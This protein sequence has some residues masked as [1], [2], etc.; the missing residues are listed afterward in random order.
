MSPTLL[1]DAGIVS[2]SANR[3]V[4]SSL[5]AKMATDDGRSL[6]ERARETFRQL[7]ALQ[8]STASRGGGSHSRR[9]C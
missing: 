1:F 5:P 2:C 4:P 8:V 9:A 3:A 6:E 7:D